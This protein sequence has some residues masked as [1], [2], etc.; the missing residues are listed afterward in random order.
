VPVDPKQKVINK[1]SKEQRLAALNNI[2]KQLEK[3]INDKS[4]GG[5]SPVKNQISLNGNKPISRASLDRTARK[6]LNEK[7][8]ISKKPYVA[9][10]GKS[11]VKAKVNLKMVPNHLKIRAQKFAKPVNKYSRKYNVDPALVLAIIHTESYFNPKARSHIPAYGLM[12]LVPR[13]G[14]RDAYRHAFGKDKK[15]NSSYLYNPENNIQL[16][17]AYL[18]L[19]SKREFKNVKN[20]TSKMYLITAAY[21]TGGGNVSKAITGNTNIY[22]ASG[23]INNMSPESLYKR[24][25]RK[26]PYKETRDYIRKVRERKKIYDSQ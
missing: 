26:L 11:R 3:I 1:L 25:E 15:P 4:V 24:L 6:I 2:K 14:G 22:K 12:Q 17:T 16:G 19:L 21:N 9:K 5:E 13:S 10:D 8:E 23:K 20:S 18:D 7:L